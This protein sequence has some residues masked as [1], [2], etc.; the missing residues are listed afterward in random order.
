M[1]VYD[2][3]PW[4]LASVPATNMA[5]NQFYC[6]ACFQAWRYVAETEEDEEDE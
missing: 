6:P 5:G 1:T 3:C 2:N 4:C